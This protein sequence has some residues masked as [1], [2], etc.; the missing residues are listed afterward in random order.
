MEFIF[1]TPAPG[2]SVPDPDRGD[3]LPEDGR[4]VPQTTYWLR[5]VDDNDV[6]V[7]DVQT[8]TQED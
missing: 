7:S 5:R 6:V 1:V 3:L 8:S 4:K 2:R